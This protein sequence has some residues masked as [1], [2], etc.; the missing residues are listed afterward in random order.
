M[1]I[2][3]LI[4]HEGKGSLLSALMEEDLATALTSSNID[5]PLFNFS[6]LYVSIALTSLGLEQ[7]DRV[8][9]IYATYLNMLRKE[10]IQYRIF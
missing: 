3:H 2:S 6:E 1:Y 8:V 7:I 10:G 4:G 5:Y 9:R